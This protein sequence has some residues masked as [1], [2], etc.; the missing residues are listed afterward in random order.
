MLLLHRDIRWFVLP[1]GEAVDCG[2]HK[3][4]RR[5]LYSLATARLRRP[6]QPL[7]RVELLAAGWPDERILPRAAANRMHVALF[8]L[9]RMGLGAWLEH[10]E[11]GWRLSPALEIEVSD[12]PS[13]PA[14]SPALPHVLMRQAG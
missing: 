1:G 2:R 13:P 3:L 8:R 9:R 10:V 6:G 7:A 5:L 14:P 4:L 11:D 12:A